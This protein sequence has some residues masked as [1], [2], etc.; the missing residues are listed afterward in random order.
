MK[1]EY[2][3]EAVF[4]ILGASSLAFAFF[5]ARLGK[6][7]IGLLESNRLAA[8]DAIKRLQD[9]DKEKTQQISHLSGQVAILKD[10]P[11]QKI[12]ES[13]ETIS[14]SHLDLTTY[15]TKHDQTVN[16][17][18]DRIIDHIDNKLSVKN[19]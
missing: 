13:L 8:N 14:R 10:I 3:I 1:P 11:L 7:T 12:S 4:I 19:T 6:D 5:R 17:G 9:N 15:M 18:V 16:A 2:I